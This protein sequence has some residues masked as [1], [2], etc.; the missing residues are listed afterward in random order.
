[1]LVVGNASGSHQGSLFQ[2]LALDGLRQPGGR[3]ATG[4]VQIGLVQ[5]EWLHQIGMGMEDFMYLA[6][7]FSIDLEP[8]AH[9]NGLRAQAVGMGGRH[10]GVN[11]ETSRFVAAGR[12]HASAVGRTTN[13]QWSPPVFRVITLLHGGVERIHVDVDY[14]ALCVCIHMDILSPNH[15]HGVRYT[16]AHGPYNRWPRFHG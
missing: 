7:R 9:E 3:I 4:Y 6:G 1:E 14:L 5:R 10:G 11:T 16:G 15:H 2:Y 13:D 12:D 8:G